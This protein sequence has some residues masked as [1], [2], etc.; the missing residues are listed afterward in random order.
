MSS[1]ISMDEFDTALLRTLNLNTS[2]IPSQ[3]PIHG[4]KLESIPEK[5][6]PVP[7]QVKV[8]RFKNVDF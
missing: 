4:E 3:T 2:T 5:A 6:T 7:G 1:N 8:D